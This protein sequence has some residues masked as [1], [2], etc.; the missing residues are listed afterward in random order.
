MK[1]IEH[2]HAAGPEMCGNR[3]QGRH[4]RGTVRQME[5]GVL[6]AEGE[7]EPRVTERH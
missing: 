1:E 6:R 4:L 3:A 7:T 5:K 2:Q